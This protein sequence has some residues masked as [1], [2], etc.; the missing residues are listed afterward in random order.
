[1]QAIQAGTQVNAV[2]IL[3]GDSVILIALTVLGPAST[4]R[5]A[6]RRILVLP[7]RPPGCRRSVE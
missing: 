3:Q 5:S 2:R 1:M 7:A 6:G 4:R